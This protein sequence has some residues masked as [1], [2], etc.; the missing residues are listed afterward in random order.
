[1][2]LIFVF[3]LETNTLFL[4]YYFIAINLLI[5]GVKKNVCYFPSLFMNDNKMLVVHSRGVYN[6]MG[7]IM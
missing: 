2:S 4:Y 1:M 3:M 7:L 6:L 5:L